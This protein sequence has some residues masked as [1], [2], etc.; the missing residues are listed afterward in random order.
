MKAN[1]SKN[2]VACSEASLLH[3]DKAQV[4]IYPH[5]DASLASLFPPQI[6]KCPYEGEQTDRNRW[7]IM[8]FVC[9]NAT[10]ILPHCK[11]IYDQQNP[12]MPS[13]IFESWCHTELPNILGLHAFPKVSTVLSSRG[14]S[15]RPIESERKTFLN[16]EPEINIGFTKF[17][18]LTSHCLDRTQKQTLGTGKHVLLWFL[19]PPET[20]Q[21][22]M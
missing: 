14:P 1:R 19:H 6:K 22:L 18:L 2:Q 17:K 10:W 12:L 8:N 3:S 11:R 16:Y 5:P 9:S 7:F 4:G 13:S 20:R 15:P 21:E